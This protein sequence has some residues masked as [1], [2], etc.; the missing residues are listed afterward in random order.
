MAQP[1]VTYIAPIT[2]LDPSPRIY[3]FYATILLPA[4]SRKMIMNQRPFAR[5]TGLA[6]ALASIC[7]LLADA[8]MKLII[9]DTRPYRPERYFMRGPGPAWRAKHSPDRNSAS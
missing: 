7:R 9:I 4:E 3:M 5:V 6:L 2:K 1:L 8:S